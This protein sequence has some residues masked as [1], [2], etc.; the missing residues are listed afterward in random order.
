MIY[1]F[2]ADG[3]EETEA[4][5]VIDVIMRA[6]EEVRTVSITD[7]KGVVG[8]HGI[9]MVADE[10]IGDVDVNLAD[11][12]F[13]PGGMPGTFNLSNCKELTDK[14][15][16]FDRLEKLLIAICAAPSVLGELGILN[17]RKATCYPGFEDKLKGANYVPDKAVSDGHIFT[18]KGMGAAI[19]LGLLVA[20][21]L[22]GKE[23]A[24]EVSESIQ[25]T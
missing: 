5:A 21:K 4:I 2:L 24:N 16:E 22:K 6:G 1:T 9:T 17:G 3:F 14:L 23:K 12:L 18:G 13:L 20:C 10:L 25:Y 19:D 8:S 11:G 15:I 7:K